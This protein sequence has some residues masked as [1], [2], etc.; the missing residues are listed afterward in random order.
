MF[1]TDTSRDEEIEIA[2]GN[3]ELQVKINIQPALTN[4][5]SQSKTRHFKNK[6]LE[7]ATKQSGIHNPLSGPLDVILGSYE[8]HTISK[9]EMWLPVV[10]TS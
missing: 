10:D 2:P 9:Q 1:L 7:N 8:P 6:H 5:V 3:V 4:A